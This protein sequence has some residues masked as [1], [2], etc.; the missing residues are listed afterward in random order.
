MAPEMVQNK[1][2]DEKIDIWSLGVL[3]FELVHGRVPFRGKSTHEKFTEI[4]NNNFTIGEDCSE[5]CR[6]LI[7]NILKP[8]PSERLSLDEIFSHP[9]MKKFE[10]SF[11]IKISEYVYNPSTSTKSVKIQNENRDDE[12]ND[13]SM[14]HMMNDT[15]NT[16]IA[17]ASFVNFEPVTLKDY[18]NVDSSSANQNKAET[19]AEIKKEET[20]IEETTMDCS[21]T[22][23]MNETNSEMKN[24][25][26][27]LLQE[28]DER[29]TNLDKYI[30]LY[31]DVTEEH[32]I[33]NKLENMSR[34]DKAKS[35]SKKNSEI[36]EIDTPAKKEN[37]GSFVTETQ[38]S[39]LHEDSLRFSFGVKLPEELD[40]K[41]SPKSADSQENQAEPFFSPRNDT[42]REASLGDCNEF[43]VYEKSP[44]RKADAPKTNG[45]I[46]K[47]AGL[48]IKVR[49]P[50]IV[51]ENL[52]SPK[53]ADESET[54]RRIHK[55][56]G[57]EASYAKTTRAQRSRV[58]LINFPI[59]ENR[60]LEDEGDQSY[61]TSKQK[62]KETQNIHEAFE[63]QKVTSSLTL[64]S[65]VSASNSTFN[66]PRNLP[67]QN[68]YSPRELDGKNPQTH[69]DNLWRF[70][71]L[72]MNKIEASSPR[73]HLAERNPKE[74]V[75]DRGH[76]HEPSITIIENNDKDA[77]SALR[78]RAMTKKNQENVGK[79]LDF[80]S[81]HNKYSTEGDSKS[82]KY[83]N[84]VVK[85]N[86][87][88]KDRTVEYTINT[89]FLSTPK[90]EDRTIKT[91]T[92]GDKY[93][94][95]SIVGFD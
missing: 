24:D 58:G 9:W 82:N 55:R 16:S 75:S 59:V 71:Q 62:E 37:F 29:I 86:Q 92:S 63:K 68:I 69:R 41:S 21:K 45:I 76:Y 65:A 64:R 79:S 50:E 11:N 38:E 67:E 70:Y 52:T 20:F 85:A 1:P 31:L 95:I 72:Q 51:T 47:K 18:S 26:T 4:L 53:S 36:T 14:S 46:S 81:Q 83:K 61:L 34:I 39:S 15:L 8:E 27:K 22:E 54:R 49:P 5:E 78:K 13:Q 89:K 32:Q 88:S 12:L 25:I 19:V 87:N 80:Q 44:R 40:N 33:L 73:S 30:K 2:H 90:K 57:S 42:V 84:P 35:S 10:K 93:R 48:S 23:L 3:L 56:A 66:T 17:D 91:K 94:I 77:L 60:E 43:A 7:T 28:H 6:D 74:I